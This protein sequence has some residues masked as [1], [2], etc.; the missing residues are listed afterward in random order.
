MRIKF[1]TSIAAFAVAARDQPALWHTTVDGR[2]LPM[3][4]KRSTPPMQRPM[5]RP[6]LDGKK[7]AA[8]FD[9]ALRATG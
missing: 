7:L 8:D 3:T 2:G 1:R 4:T 5:T 6:T 9:P